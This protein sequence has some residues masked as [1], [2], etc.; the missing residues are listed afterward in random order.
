MQLVTLSENECRA[1]LARGHGG[2][3]ACANGAQPYVVPFTY[4]YDNDSLYAFTM[5]GKKVEWM[6]ANPAVCVVVEERGPGRNWQSVIVD[7]RF[8]ELPD[9][10]GH[11]QSREHAWE[12]LSRHANWWE[13]GGMKPG[14]LTPS[15]R[16]PNLFFRVKVES[17]SGRRAIDDA[18]TS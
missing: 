8:E 3:L 16:S 11:K 7:G 17:L 5:P 1:L 18:A 10:V 15:D 12:L 6:R 4:A 13:P 2:H 9:H 14:L